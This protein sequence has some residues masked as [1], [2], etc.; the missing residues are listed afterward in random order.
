MAGIQGY[1]WLFCMSFRNLRGVSMHCHQPYG[2]IGY[3]KISA[4][5]F[6][7][8][9]LFALRDCDYCFRFSRWWQRITS[10][11]AELL[12][13]KTSSKCR[14]TTIDCPSLLQTRNFIV[15]PILWNSGNNLREQHDAVV[16]VFLRN[17]IHDMNTL[18]CR[19]PPTNSASGSS[20]HAP[21][22]ERP[23]DHAVHGNHN[24]ANYA[25]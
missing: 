3:S 17:W 24:A 20:T 5:I 23:M 12:L 15:V 19:L 21:Y 10:A 9:G 18:F 25:R 7:Y 4:S 13:T 2:H 1:G 14:S 6:S 16:L 8:I 11:N 22:M